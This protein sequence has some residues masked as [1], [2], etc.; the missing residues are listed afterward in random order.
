MPD[1]G[2]VKVWVL[3]TVVAMGVGLGGLI[4]IGCAVGANACPFVD[5]PFTSTDGEE[6][7]LANCALCHGIDAAGSPQNARAPSLVD[8]P[9]AG[10]TRAELVARIQDGSVGLMPRFEGKL[11]DE[12]IR[13]VAE[14]VLS[15]R[16]DS[17][18]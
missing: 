2:S 10:L 3:A 13:A 15:L 1:T 4:G 12:Q 8:G 16:E 11:T 17:D 7:W 5:E 14:Y 18:G 6:I 9:S